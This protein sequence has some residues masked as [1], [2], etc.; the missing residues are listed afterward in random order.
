[1]SLALDIR[2][3]ILVYETNVKTTGKVVYR[4]YVSRKLNCG[5]I[6]GGVLNN[7]TSLGAATD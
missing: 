3:I 2:Y 4:Y 5:A 6:D 1:M 7:K